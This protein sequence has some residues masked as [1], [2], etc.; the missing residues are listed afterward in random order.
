MDGDSE[1]IPAT[2]PKAAKQAGEAHM[3]WHWVEPSVWTDR[4]LAALENGVK[5]GKWFSLIDKVYNLDN[6][7]AAVDK[8]YGN[9]P[10]E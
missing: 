9:K 2:V 7:C 6:L 1:T 5:G 10:R 3:R 4:M 8:V